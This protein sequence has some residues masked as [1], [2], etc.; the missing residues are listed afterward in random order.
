MINLIAILPPKMHRMTHA[1]F[2]SELRLII[3]NNGSVI[4]N[5]HKMHPYLIDWRKRVT[6]QTL[7][8]VEPQHVADILLIV[9]LCKSKNITIT[10]QGGNTGGCGGCIPGENP[11]II[12]SLRQLNKVRD[13]DPIGQTLTVESGCT[14]DYVQAITKPD[15]LYFP[16]SLSSSKNC[17]IGGN[18]ATN[19]GGYCVV[20]NGMTRNNVLGIEVVL[21]NGHLYSDLRKLKKNNDSYDFKNIFLGS[22]GTLGIITAAVLELKHLPIDHIGA[23][24]GATNLS[25]TIE[26]IHELKK[27]LEINITAVEIFSNECL[28]LVKK[29]DNQCEI[30]IDKYDWYLIIDIGIYHVEQKTVYHNILSGVLNKYTHSMSYHVY[31]TEFDRYQAWKIRSTIPLAEKQHSGYIIKNDISLPLSSWVSFYKEAQTLK[32]HYPEMSFI[33]FG[34]I[35]DGSLHFNI[36][37]RREGEEQIKK[38]LYQIVRHYQGSIAAEHG[39]GQ[40]KLQDVEEFHSNNHNTLMRLIKKSLDPQ[41]IFNPGKA[42]SYE[43][44]SRKDH[45]F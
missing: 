38:D 39:V 19:A 35:G 16:L 26:F 41:N 27:S 36:Q 6:G 1:D 9:D 12:L 4:T 43:H 42:V 29:L 33:I 44:P 17:T 40:T 15:Q 10:P 5:A 24:V 8:I 30:K 37:H 25:T 7:A 34:H 11:N 2:I 23:I 22:E 31:S 28:D 3:K 13:Y 20:Q 14:L 21:S 18:L 45:I 32:K